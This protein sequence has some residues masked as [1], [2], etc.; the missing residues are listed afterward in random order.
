MGAVAGRQ[1][2]WRLRSGLSLPRRPKDEDQRA[3]PDGGQVM[4]RLRRALPAY[5][6][7]ACTG[8]SNCRI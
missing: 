1:A 8:A 2:V 7:E 6:S 5:R 4:P 3:Q